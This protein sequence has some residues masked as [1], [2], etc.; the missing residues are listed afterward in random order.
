MFIPI[1]P[2]WKKHGV[3]RSRLFKIVLSVKGT[4]S[5]IKWYPY[6]IPKANIAQRKEGE[7]WNNIKV[8]DISSILLE[9]WFQP[10]IGQTRWNRKNNLQQY[11]LST[12]PASQQNRSVQGNL[13][14]AQAAYYYWEMN[15]MV[16]IMYHLYCLQGKQFDQ[17]LE[18]ESI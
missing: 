2:T 8:S 11:N 17:I 6:P 9:F 3:C 5:K 10:L 18:V 7:E 15:D 12:P 13:M 14:H 4:M 1:C 16:Q